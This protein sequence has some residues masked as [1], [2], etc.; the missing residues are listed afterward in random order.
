MS[1]RTK[2]TQAAIVEG[3]SWGPAFA[4]EMDL[5]IAQGALESFRTGQTLYDETLR[6]RVAAYCLP[7]DGDVVERSLGVID[8]AENP[9]ERWKEVPDAVSVLAGQPRGTWAIFRKGGR[10][11]A[12]MSDGIG[13]VGTASGEKFTY[14]SPEAPD[15]QFA[16]VYASVISWAVYVRRREIE[17]EILE[18]SFDVAG[19]KDGM[20]ATQARLGGKEYARVEY[21]GIMKDR[22]GPGR[23][24]VEVVAHRRGVRPT[25]YALEKAA[26]ARTFELPMAMPAAYEGGPDRLTSVSERRQGIAERTVDALE[27]PEGLARFGSRAH[28][29]ERGDELSRFAYIEGDAPGFPSGRVA[30]TFSAGGEEVLSAVYEMDAPAPRP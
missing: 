28:F 4:R 8:V 15:L 11:D 20:V 21:A 9:A 30:V 10:Y 27:K 12:Y 6:R 13:G 29:V 19:S 24:A 16:N 18:N 5:V 1:D 7:L 17:G 26:F 2:F 23:D 25:R 3:K 22:N 14:A